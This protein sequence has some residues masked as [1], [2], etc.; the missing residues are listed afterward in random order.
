MSLKSNIIDDMKNA[1]RAKDKKQ[2]GTIRL[3]TAAIKQIEV[4][5]RKELSDADVVAIVVKMVKQRKD[6]TKQYQ[7]ANR[8]DLADQEIYEIGVLEKYLPEQLS[9]DDIEDLIKKAIASTDAKG[10]QDMG[11]VMGLLRPDLAGRADMGLVSQKIKAL[12]QA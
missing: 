2:L 10:M 4:D 5:E 11:K 7:D 1:M 3:L 6:S 8:H 9:E 12:L